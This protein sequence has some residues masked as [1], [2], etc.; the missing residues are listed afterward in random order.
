MGLFLLKRLA[1]MLI[2]L[3]LASMVVFAVLEI[4]PGN[5]AQVMLGPDAAPDA[6]QALERKLGLDQPAPVRYGQWISGLLQG[7]LG[8][9]HAYGSPVAQLI[10]QRMAL[11]IPLALLAMLLASVLAL[12]AGVYAAARH[13]RAADMAVMG[14]S[15]LGMAVPGFWFAMLLVLLFAVKLRWFSAGG[16]DGWGS[17]PA[18]WLAAI[19]SL[20]LPAWALA[21]VQAAMLTRLTRT[22]VL[23][24]LQEDFVRSARARGLSQ[25]T[26]LFRHVL[27]HALGPVLTLSGLQ[28]ANLMAGAI[29]IENVFFLPGLGRL[30]FQ[31]I[32][33]RDLI[34]VRNGVLM[35]AACVIVVNAAIDLLQAWIDPRLRQA[36][37]AHAEAHA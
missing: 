31:S 15:Q 3:L 5:A 27:R 32:A 26:V 4:L 37:S 20:L 1:A 28:F 25:R 7:Q 2:T 36:Q 35:L 13:G 33:N 9:S 18:Q 16:F 23:E 19:K 30:L 22:A 17:H 6:V 34:V 21:I 10:A 24:V 8:I 11:T 29:V 12:A 14:L